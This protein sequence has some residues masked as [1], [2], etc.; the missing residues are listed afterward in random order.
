MRTL[1]YDID[2]T[3]LDHS[4]PKPLLADGAFERLV[5]AAQFERLVCVGNVGLII[6]ALE[7]AGLPQDGLGTVW[8]SCRGC[9]EDEAWFRAATTL[10]AMV[11]VM[12]VMLQFPL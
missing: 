3:L 4:V 2:G 5:R 9:F 6:Q 7:R 11:S 1:Y 10:V 12:M 8:R